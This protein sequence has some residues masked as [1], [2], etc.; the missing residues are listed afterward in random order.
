MIHIPG[1]GFLFPVM[2]HRLT[3]SRG[4]RRATDDGP[5]DVSRRGEAALK[6]QWLHMIGGEAY[7][8][9]KA[10]KRRDKYK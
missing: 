9:G 5:A 10:Y 6:M 2:P 8:K 7:E 4:V 1:R 3:P